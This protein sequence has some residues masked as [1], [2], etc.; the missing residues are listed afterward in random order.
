MADSDSPGPRLRSIDLLRGLVMVLMALDH[1]RDY[2]SNAAFDPLDLART[3]TAFYFTRWVTHLCAPTFIL[4]AGVSAR[5]VG[6]RTTRGQLARFL[7]TR[8]LWLIVLEVT[9]VH[10]AWSFNLRY[11][12]GVTLQVIWAIGASMVVL[13]GLVRLPLWLI[14]VISAL[15]IAGHNAF[16]SVTGAGWGALEVPWQ[17]L[18]VPGPQP[19][20]FI[21]Y[22]LVPWVGL[23]A[24]GYL[25]GGVYGWDAARRVRTLGWLALGSLGGFVLLRGLNGYGDPKPWA[26]QNSA[27]F[28]VLSFLD[29]TKYPPSL[30]YVAIMLGLGCALLALF[31]RFD[32]ASSRWRSA[33]S[34]FGRVPLF[35]YVLHMLLLH[36]F[37]GVIA[38]AMGQGSHV[39][40]HM[41]LDFEP[42]WGFE[43]TVV[44]LV[45]AVVVLALYPACSWFAGWKRRRAASWWVSYL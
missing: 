34:V 23:M 16:D 44:Y 20:G 6:R 36:A 13:A 38:L 5:L 28:S 27:W 25:L 39:L 41:F 33:L 37:A 22:P 14:A 32:H 31:E 12:R 8:G 43:L 7:L 2:F 17:L 45:W 15:L 24:L 4:L 10:F 42:G 29:V 35:F 11:E 1:V 9:V 21:V 19:F 3:S 26:A 30:A 40:T 18:H